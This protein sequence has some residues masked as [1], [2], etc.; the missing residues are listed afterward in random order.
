M[1]GLFKSKV[2]CPTCERVSLTFDPFL[3]CSLPIPLKS[4]RILEFYYVHADNSRTP[5]G[6]KI[7]YN[8]NNSR[9]SNIKAELAG[10]AGISP[11]AIDMCFMTY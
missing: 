4:E 11:K 6:L 5:W 1:N 3:T 7:K 10:Y 8:P 9:I 2:T